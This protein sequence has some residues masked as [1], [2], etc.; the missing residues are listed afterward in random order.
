[1]TTPPRDVC[2]QLRD[3]LVE[4]RQD[5]ATHLDRMD[6]HLA[7]HQAAQDP[8]HGPSDPVPAPGTGEPRAAYLRG[9]ERRRRDRGNEETVVAQ[10]LEACGARRTDHTTASFVAHLAARHGLEPDDVLGIGV[11]LAHLWTDPRTEYTITLD[12]STPA[13]SVEEDKHRAHL[14]HHGQ[15]IATMSPARAH[16]IAAALNDPAGHRAFRR[17]RDA[18]NAGSKA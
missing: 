17:A 16:G 13:W 4:M 15:R 7:A 1:M 6:R 10:M 5:V 12:P 8:P 11:R 14:L 9:T 2:A 3:V 18:Y